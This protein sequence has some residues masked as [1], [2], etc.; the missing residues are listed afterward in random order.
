MNES[1][2]VYAPESKITND[3]IIVYGA[4]KFGESALVLN[5]IRASIL[6]IELWKFLNQ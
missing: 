4:G 6:M 5:K 3:S 2:L 1:N